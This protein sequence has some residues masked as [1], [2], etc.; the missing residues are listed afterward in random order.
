MSKRV[1][2]LSASP[3]K[4]GNS[5]V[6]CD[7]FMAG[8]SE[9]GHQVEKIFLRDKT[10]NYCLGCG[11]CLNSKTCVQ[12]DDMAEILDK[13]VKADAIVMATPVYFYCMNAQL[14]TLIDRTVPKYTAISS[15]E[16]YLIA[17]AAD[18]DNSAMEETIAGFRGFLRCVPNPTEAGIIYGTGAW[19]V[20]EIKARP[21]MQQAYEMGKSV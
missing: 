17:T 5:D 1:L 21:A 6:L 7:Q 2:I 9:S 4:H 16:F 19:N 15:K 8:A 18:G 20:G 3:R 14:K 13:M 10:I 11:A 12:K